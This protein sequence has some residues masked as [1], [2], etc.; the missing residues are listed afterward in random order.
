MKAMCMTN[1]IDAGTRNVRLLL[2]HGVIITEFAQR[3][4]EGAR[5]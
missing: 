5:V 1:V 2:P 3:V 4:R